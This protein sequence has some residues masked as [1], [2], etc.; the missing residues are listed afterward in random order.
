MSFLPPALFASRLD[1]GEALYLSHPLGPLEP[2]DV[3]LVVA[4]DGAVEV[5]YPWAYLCGLPTRRVSP[6]GGD[7]SPGPCSARAVVLVDD[8]ML[9]PD[10]LE[11]LLLRLRAARPRM[12]TVVAPVLRGPAR[13][14]CRRA[15]VED[16]RTLRPASDAEGRRRI[17]PQQ[18][19]CRSVAAGLLHEIDRDRRA[20][21]PTPLRAVS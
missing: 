10:A 18:P 2:A 14:A 16:L 4:S 7:P 12:L 11:R 5:A 20:P 17:Y 1:A 21:E 15:G 3:Q 8:G 19:V 9:A 6:A 13:Q